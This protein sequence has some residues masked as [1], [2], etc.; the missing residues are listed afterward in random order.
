MP[1]DDSRRI[2]AG[3]QRSKSASRL[4][5]W[6]CGGWATLINPGLPGNRPRR[7]PSS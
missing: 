5:S 4:T 7:Q 6:W 1:L 2:V 3:M